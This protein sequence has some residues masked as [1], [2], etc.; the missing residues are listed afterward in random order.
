MNAA[1]IPLNLLS[2][3]YVASFVKCLCYVFSSLLSIIIPRLS[4]RQYSLC[5]FIILFLIL[6][7]VKYTIH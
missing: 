6:K 3:R 4:H 7:C 5:H 2:V 1:T